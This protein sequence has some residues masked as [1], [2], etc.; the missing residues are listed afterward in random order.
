M[1]HRRAINEKY[2]FAAESIIN[3]RHGFVFTHD[4]DSERFENTRY[5]ISAIPL[6]PFLL[7]GLVFFLIVIT[8]FTK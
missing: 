2:G 6:M 5:V 4:P 1:V 8:I 3:G 7:G